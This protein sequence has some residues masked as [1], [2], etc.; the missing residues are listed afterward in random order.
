MA[1][2]P[3]R[4]AD[5]RDVADF[6]LRWQEFRATAA[7]V[8]GRAVLTP[9]ERWVI[10]WLIALADRVGESDVEPRAPSNLPYSQIAD[11]GDA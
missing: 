5:V 1:R 9:D 11:P 2:A 3:T 10:G 6:H 8:A 7:R 4:A